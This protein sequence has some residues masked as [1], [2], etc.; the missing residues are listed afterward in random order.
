MLVEPQDRATRHNDDDTPG[1]Q[2]KPTQRVC[3]NHANLLW[4]QCHCR[5]ARER[6]RQ[7]ILF[8]ARKRIGTPRAFPVVVIDAAASVAD[9]TFVKSV[10]R[11]NPALL[12]AVRAVH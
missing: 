4:W 9:P 8:G 7:V 5:S 10:E 3:L 1:V 2:T 6:I 12:L 11:G